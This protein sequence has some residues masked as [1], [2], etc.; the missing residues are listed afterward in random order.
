[1]QQETTTNKALFKHRSYRH[2]NQCLVKKRPHNNFRVQHF[3]KL[4]FRYADKLPSFLSSC[5]IQ[6]L[7]YVLHIF[8]PIISNQA[9]KG[10]YKVFVYYKI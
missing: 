3:L 8:G 10:Y 1:M 2:V 7:L 5:L 4:I 9:A 6:W